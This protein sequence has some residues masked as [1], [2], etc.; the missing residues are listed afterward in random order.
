[1]ALPK[2]KQSPKRGPLGFA[3]KV[4]IAIVLGLSFAVIWSTISPT[5]S[6]SEVST[7]RNSFEGEILDP[8]SKTPTTGKGKVQGK[9]RKKERDTS[10]EKSNSN[11]TVEASKPEEVEVKEER[12]EEHREEGK[13]EE[14]REEQ[15]EGEEQ[16]EGENKEEQSGTEPPTSIFPL[17]PTYHI[18][19]YGNVVVP[20]CHWHTVHSRLGLY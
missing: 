10:L 16:R 20:D 7:K 5:S 4:S 14:A 11:A 8:E 15:G 3:A 13:E 1:M 17:L 12:E 19:T 9:E 18:V 6:E 2:L